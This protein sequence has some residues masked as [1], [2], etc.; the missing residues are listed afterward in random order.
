SLSVG[1]AVCV[2]H[3]FTHLGCACSFCSSSASCAT[4]AAAGSAKRSNVYHVT[5][6]S[7]VPRCSP[8]QQSTLAA[9]DDHQVPYLVVR[10]SPAKQA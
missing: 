8:V 9:F 10:M 7:C 1:L 5:R 2:S 3:C 4:A 6:W